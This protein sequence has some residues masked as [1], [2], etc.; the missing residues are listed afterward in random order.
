M[1]ANAVASP[2]VVES[3]AV[4]E[5]PDQQGRGRGDDDGGAQQEGERQGQQPVDELVAA[6]VVAGRLGDLGDEDG[7]ED[8]AG[9]QQV[10][11]VGQGVGHLEGVGRQGDAHGGREQ[12]RPGEPEQPRDRRCRRP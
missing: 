12:R 5:Q 6:V 1:K 2:R 3:H 4:G 7:V 8:A 10:E 9:Q 11:L